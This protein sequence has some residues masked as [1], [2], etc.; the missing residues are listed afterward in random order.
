[1]LTLIL[2][3][4]LTALYA[5]LGAAPG[6][7]SG[8]IA[9]S[10]RQQVGGAGNVE[11]RLESAPPLHLLSGHIDRLDL[12]LEDFKVEGVAIASASLETA[13]FDTLWT[14]RPLFVHPAEATG[15]VDIPEAGLLA[16]L[17]RPEIRSKL[18][19][20]PLQIPIFPGLPP[21][22]RKVDVV[23]ERVR[24]TRNRLGIEGRVEVSGSAWPVAVSIR[25]DLVAPD[26]LHISNLELSL[27]GRT[28]PVPPSVLQSLLPE[29][30][31]LKQLV[32]GG[33][34]EWSLVGLQPTEGRLHL[35]AR[36]R[37]AP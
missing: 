14:G 31:E 11:V 10:L 12:K 32:P 26:R 28:V 37:L 2:A 7:I 8:S 29:P 24:V 30:I 4:V 27:G 3:C 13:P 22:Q 35:L 16:V 9:D 34:P 33:G 6:L 17:E 21:I 20:I 5:G 36:I 19:G 1:M 23:P 25:P 18:R 15:S